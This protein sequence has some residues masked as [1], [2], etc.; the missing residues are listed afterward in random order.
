MIQ[1]NYLL[2]NNKREEYGM[3]NM[4]AIKSYLMIFR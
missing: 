3:R 2:N 4:M 1:I